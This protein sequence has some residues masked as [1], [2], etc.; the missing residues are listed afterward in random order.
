MADAKPRF[1]VAAGRQEWKASTAVGAS[2]TAPQRRPAFDAGRSSRRLKGLTTTTQEINR[3]IRSYG[4]TVV[5]RSRYLSQN[6]PYAMQAKKVFVSALAGSGIKPSSLAEADFKAKLQEVWLDWTDEADADGLTDLYGMQ[7]TIASEMFDAGECFIRLRARRP[8]DGL[9]V[10]LQLQL[11]PSEMLPLNDNRMLA[12]GNY[13]QMGVEF[14]AIGKRVAYWFL[15]QHPGADQVNFRSGFAGEQVRVPAEEVLH[16]FDPTGFAGQIR[17]IPHTLSGIVTAAVL[18]CYDDAELERKRVAALFGGFITTELGDDAA[19]HPMAEG[20]EAAQAAGKD[21]AIALEPGAMLDL[22]PGQDVTFAEPADVGGNYE[23]FQYR[24]LLRMA[25]GFGVPYAA[26]TGDLRQANYGSIRAGLVEFRRRIEAM[27]H[28]VMVFQ[29]CR[30]VWRRFMNDA[31]LAGRLPVGPAQYLAAPH[32]YRR[33]KWI[34]PR[35][36]WVDPLKDRQAEKLAVDAGF[37]ARSDVIEAEGYDPEE[38][39]QRIAADRAREKR[40]GLSFAPAKAPPPAA[41]AKE[42]DDK[43]EQTGD[44]TDGA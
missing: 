15:R 24:N 16:L 31:V 23:A 38:T 18:D 3:L 39:D 4:R 41:A 43:P 35:W 12:D 36:D 42:E 5:A 13:V 10:P 26:M 17:G 22:D 29:F 30:P 33:A 40:L 6:N 9:I 2:M 8:E 1:R 37:K 19:P 27:Q 44:K 28:A 32:G 21:S 25:A 11:L 20:I 34:A 7:A 14:N